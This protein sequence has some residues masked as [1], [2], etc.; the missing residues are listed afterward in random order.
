MILEPLVRQ[1]RAEE[2]ASFFNRKKE[3]LVVVGGSGLAVLLLTCLVSTWMGQRHIQRRLEKL[4]NVELQE[5]KLK[6]LD[7]M[8][9]SSALLQNKRLKNRWHHSKKRHNF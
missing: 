5:V 2:E 1:V 8:L 6:M 7:D 3:V 4:K 9:K